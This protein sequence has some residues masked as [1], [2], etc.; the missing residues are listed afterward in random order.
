MRT[1]RGA[2]AAAAGAG[3]VIGSGITAGLLTTCGRP[4]P[5]PVAHAPLQT[6]VA[7]PSVSVRVHAGRVLRRINPLIYGVAVAKPEDLTALRP[8]LHRWGGNPSSRYNWELG[9]AWNAAR[10]WEF[11]NG[12]YDNDR[13]EHLRP[14]GVADEF[15]ER[16]RAIGAEPVISVPAMG[17]VAGNRS[18]ETRS[19]NVPP[20]GGPQAPGY[21]PAFNRMVTSVRSRAR[22]G[23]PFAATPDLNDGTVYQDEWVHHLVQRFGTAERGGVRHYVVDNEPDLWDGTHTDVHPEQP[24]YAELRDVFHESA[25]AIKDVDP[26]A[27]VWGPAL[28]GWTAYHFSPRDRGDDNFRAHAERRKHGNEPFL[29]WWLEQI[30]RHD[31]RTGRRTLDVLNVHYYPQAGG[32]YSENDDANMTALRLRSTRS[33]WDQ[34]YVDESWIRETVTLVPRLRGWIDRHY[35]GTQLAI[36]EWNWGAE[37]SIG[38]ALAIADVLGIFGREGVDMAAYWTVPPAGSPAALAFSLFTDPRKSGLG[39]GD[40]ALAVDHAVPADELAVYAARDTKSLEVVVLAINKRQDRQVSLAVSLE[41]VAAKGSARLFQ[42]TRSGVRGPEEVRAPGALT[43]PPLS[44][45][46][47]RLRT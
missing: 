28:S 2:L 47:L 1:R 35:P 34:G 41:G 7:E 18:L 29:P 9:N 3:A 12:T 42:L 38:G 25:L 26:T 37:R 23:A 19:Q 11:R 46:L 21:D 32:V 33:L 4:A 10:D 45:S 8:T 22:K 44:A 24:G 36:G 16:T 15:I 30:K 17:W 5:P 40:A 6:A 13:P 43:L 20:G 14:S 39:F 27:K 31:E